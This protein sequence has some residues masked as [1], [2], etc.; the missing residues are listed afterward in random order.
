MEPQKKH[1]THVPGQL[2]GYTLQINRALAHL[3]ECSAGDVASIEVFEDTGL[4]KSD[5]KNLAEQAKSAFHNNPIAD[6]SVE[7]WKTMSNWVDEV[8]LGSL[9]PDSTTLRIYVANEC[10]AG[11]IPQSF[12]DAKTIDQAAKAL[13]DA[14]TIMVNPSSTIKKYVENV[15]HADNVSI[16]HKVIV[17]M[18]TDNGT[19]HQ[20]DDLRA[21]LRSKMAD[22][23]LIDELLTHSLGWVLQRFQNAR[24]TNRPAMIRFDDL[25]FEMTTFLKAHRNNHVLMSLANQPS[26]TEVDQHKPKNYVKQLSL[27]DCEPEEILSAIN[28]YFM[29]AADRTTWAVKGFVTKTS[30]DDFE[31]GLNRVWTNSKKAVILEKGQGDPLLVGKLIHLACM[32]HVGSLQG[33][34]VPSHFTPGCFHI[35]ADTLTIGWHPDYKGSITK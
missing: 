12:N 7:L 28:D 5:G 33:M 31:K 29:A 14:K 19:G 16:A 1:S 25:R 35:L 6:K 27:I 30:L 32:K 11:K 10:K 9:D 23:D 21:L 20:D 13:S 17:A 8:K 4:S 18:E 3:L 2:F 34:E 26:R 22:E 15:V 24:Q